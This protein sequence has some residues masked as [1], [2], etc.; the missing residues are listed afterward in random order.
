MSLGPLTIYEKVDP[1]LLKHV[2]TSFKFALSDGA[3]PRKIKLLIAMALDASHGA[4]PGVKSLAKAAIDAGATKE[5]ILEA[6]RVAQY[7]SGVGCVYVASH[8]I[9]EIF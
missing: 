5:E 6:I 2:E 7:I 8:A 4:V 1:E 9:K 3:L